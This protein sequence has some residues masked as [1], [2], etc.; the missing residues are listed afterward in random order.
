MFKSIQIAERGNK[1]DQHRQFENEDYK[2]ISSP[3]TTKTGTARNK[4]KHNRSKSNITR[5]NYRQ[6]HLSVETS[7][8][9]TAHRVN[10]LM[11]PY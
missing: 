1:V 10:L 11:F 4:V 3:K 2:Q 5:T 8:L 6:R 7:E 9:G